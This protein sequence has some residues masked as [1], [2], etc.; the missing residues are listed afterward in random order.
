ME[1]Q[2]VFQAKTQAKNIS[3][4][5]PPCCP[6][7]LIHELP[8]V[9]VLLRLP[10]VPGIAVPFPLEKVL[11]LSI[12]GNSL[13][14]D[15][16]YRIFTISVFDIVSSIILSLHLAI[17]DF[18]RGLHASIKSI[19]GISG[20]LALYLLHAVS[21]FL[22]Y[23]ARTSIPL[24]LVLLD[25]RY[26]VVAAQVI[27]NQRFVV[28]KPQAA[29]DAGV[30][31]SLGDV[32]HGVA[33]RTFLEQLTMTEPEVSS[34][35]D[36]PAK[37]HAALC[38]QAL[39]RT[40]VPKDRRGSSD[41]F[42]ITGRTINSLLSIDGEQLS[43]RMGREFVSSS[44]VFVDDEIV[45]Q[46]FLATSQALVVLLHQGEVTGIGLVVVNGG[47]VVVADPQVAHGGRPTIVH[48]WTDLAAELAFVDHQASGR[49]TLWDA[50]FPV[51]DSSPFWHHFPGEWHFVSHA[52]M[53][54]H[55]S[56]VLEEALSA[57][58]HRTGDIILLRGQLEGVVMSLPLAVHLKDVPG[59]APPRVLLIFAVFALV[60]ASVSGEV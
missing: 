22:P 44:D 56:P 32:V 18:L 10:R 2:P 35:V 28:K 16:L 29:E 55:Q 23:V 37:Q 51:R 45:H 19:L 33:N 40:C 31:A 3:I 59:H 46:E 24:S 41:G 21:S 14:E 34:H 30:P 39:E 20:V 6:L 11:N 57:G 4:E 17:R 50:S 42:F 49:L 27:H 25:V 15:F 36:P 54:V 47:Q 58:G 13:L 5:L 38:N 1:S 60:L 52:H 8:A 43:I 9:E 12:R 26:S 53:S 48:F 7:E